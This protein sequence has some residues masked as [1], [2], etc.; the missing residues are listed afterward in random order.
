MAAELT[1]RIGYIGAGWTDRVQIPAFTLG[2]LQPQAIAARSVEN[3]RRVAAKHAIPDVYEHWQDL[4][5]AENVD[6]VSICTPPDTHREMAVAAL[7]AGKHVICEKP[8]ALNVEEAEAMFAAAQAAPGQLAI[9]DHELRFHPMRL[10][11]RQMLKEGAIGTLIRIDLTRLGSDRLDPAF[12]FTWWSDAEK[13]GGM[14]GATGSHCIDTARWLVGRLEAVAGQLQIGHHVRVDKEGR[15]REVTADD[16]ADMLVRFANGVQGRLVATG[17]NPGGYGVTTL[18]T[19]S[20]GALKLDSEDRL[21][22]QRGSAYPGDE[23]EAVRPRYTGEDLSSLPS[24]GPFAVGSYYLAQTL[25]TML[26]MGDTALPEAASFY[27]GL[28]VQRVL[29]AVRRSA[30]EGKWQSL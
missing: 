18:L 6:I 7:K 11:L 21:W 5:Q 27:D 12:P 26:P 30:A 8:M 29:D 17:L 25:S 9:I 10:Q 20:D 24:P 2:G 13:G 4:V 23:W 1:P 22:V 3:A 28:V 15:R 16:H 14:L 19:G